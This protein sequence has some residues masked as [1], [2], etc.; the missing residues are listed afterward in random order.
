MAHNIETPEPKKTGRRKFIKSAAISAP[1]MTTLASK[2]VWAGNCSLSGNLSGNTS[3]HD[4]TDC[5]NFSGYSP[6]GWKDGHAENHGYWDLIPQEKS[7]ALSSS[8]AFSF[9]APANLSI[10]NGQMKSM[11]GGETLFNALLCNNELEKQ[12]TA[13]LLNASLAENSSFDY[14]YSVADIQ[15]I[16]TQLKTTATP[17]EVVAFISLLNASQ[18]L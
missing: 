12:M 15:A 16:Y 5:L 18:T 14:P 1:L 4:R 8:L 2:P 7:T 6:G 13:A 17:E 10:P 9:D 3:T 11:I